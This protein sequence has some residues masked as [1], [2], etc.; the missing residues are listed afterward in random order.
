MSPEQA[1]G[2]IADRPSDIWAYGAVLYELLTGKQ[3]FA[4]DTVSDILA[5]VLKTEPDW[6][7]LDAFP[8]RVVNLIRRC[9][10]KDRKQRLPWIGEARFALDVSDVAPIETRTSRIRWLPWAIAGIATLA[11]AGTLLPRRSSPADEGRVF[12]ARNEQHFRFGHLTANG[13]DSSQTVKLKKI[14]ATGGL[15]TSLAPVLSGKGGTWNKQGDI[16]FSPGNTPLYRM[17]R[18]WGQAGC[19][20]GVANERRRE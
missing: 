20:K 12:P 13:S 11:L 4:G 17:F 18:K 3:A 6:R 19:N 10:V 2:A 8:A 5:S 14:E 1:R 15:V 7:A 16:V 9:L